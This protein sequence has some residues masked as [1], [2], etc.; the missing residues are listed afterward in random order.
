MDINNKTRVAYRCPY[1]GAVI[2]F[3]VTPERLKS[4][5]NLTCIQC[6]KSQMEISMIPG[7]VVCLTVP[8][9]MCPHSHPYK[10]SLE[11]FFSKD[12]Y[13]FPCSFSGLDVCFIGTDEDLVDDEIDASGALIRAMLE[14][15]EQ[16]DLNA[17][18]ANVMVADTAVMREVVFAI[19]ELEKQKKIKCSCQ[20]KSV[21]VLLDYD[22]AIIVC[23]VCSN[24]KEIPARTRL[25]A[26]AA[27]DMEMI[28]F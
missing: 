5:F 3:D 10:I 8:C 15:T 17:N 26:S 22:K 25:D 19:G 11:M 7:D 1:C 18:D 27:I 2:T 24:K 16:E 14:E 9:L 12:I 4:R 28:E 20:S 21:K 23:K 13:T 6:H